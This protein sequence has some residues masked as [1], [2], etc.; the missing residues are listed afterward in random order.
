MSFLA[1]ATKLAAGFCND[2]LETSNERSLKSLSGTKKRRRF[3]STSSPG[4]RP[5]RQWLALKNVDKTVEPSGVIP[6]R[7]GGVGR[8]NMKAR[9]RC[10]IAGTILASCLALVCSALAWGGGRRMGA[11]FP[12]LKNEETCRYIAHLS[13]TVTYEVCMAEER[14]ARQELERVWASFPASARKQCTNIVVPPAFPSYLS[15]QD[16]L[17]YW[18]IKPASGGAG[19]GP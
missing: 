13:T 3:R 15:L 14:T 10:L 1:K 16:C 18:E 17:S 19:G 4:G 11:A 6:E 12:E 7:V 8:E 2:G 5:H 9:S